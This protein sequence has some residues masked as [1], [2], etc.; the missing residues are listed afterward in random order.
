MTSVTLT[1]VTSTLRDR[2]RDQ[3]RREIAEAALALAEE[4]GWAQVTVSDL[5]TEVGISRRAFFTH[6]ATKDDAVVHGAT[7]DLDFLHQA[8]AS[9]PAGATFVDVLR[10]SVDTWLDGLGTLGTTRR[11]RQRIEAEHPEVAAKIATERAAAL[12]RTALP[13]V[14]ADLG[15]GEDHPVAL[16]VA[17]AFAGLGSTLDTLFAR[18]PDAARDHVELSLALLDA[19]VER[20]ARLV[21]SP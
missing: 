4:R 20:A 16:M 1:P 5:A 17:S 11:R 13:A 3:L 21:A 7:D 15:T 8:L 19:L 6:F 12:R 10:A 2:R 9:R 18:D 14:A